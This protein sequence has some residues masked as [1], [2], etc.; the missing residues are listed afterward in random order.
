MNLVNP[1]V[2]DVRGDILYEEGG[3]LALDPTPEAVKAALKI[4]INGRLIE[5]RRSELLR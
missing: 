2:Q 1:L 5:R 3:H 4:I